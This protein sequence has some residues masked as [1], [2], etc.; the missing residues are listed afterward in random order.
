M[1]EAYHYI[2]CYKL[3][4]IITCTTPQQDLIV[5]QVNSSTV[6]AHCIL[7]AQFLAILVALLDIEERF[8]FVFPCPRGFN[9]S[10]DLIKINVLKKTNVTATLQPLD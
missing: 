5:T 7:S 3:Q 8:A 2:H 10:T 1:P 6:V 9:S 4:I